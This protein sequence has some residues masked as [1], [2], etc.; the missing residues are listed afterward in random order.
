MFS[1]RR[2]VR[3]FRLGKND[4]DLSLSKIIICLPMTKKIVIV[5]GRSSRPF[6]RVSLRLCKQAFLEKSRAHGSFQ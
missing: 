2:G 1:Q 3:F 6:L 4:D 5:F